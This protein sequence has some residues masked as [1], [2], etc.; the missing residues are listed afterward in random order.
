MEHTTSATGQHDFPGGFPTGPGQHHHCTI[1]LLLLHVLIALGKKEYCMVIVLVCSWRNLMFCP[2]VMA[3]VG[4]RNGSGGIST[5]LLYTGQFNCTWEG[6]VLLCHM[7]S[8]IILNH[9]F[10]TYR[11]RR[12]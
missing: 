10:C 9:E 12:G 8:V 7:N 2:L 5:R 1:E 4:M 6:G 11:R 3:P